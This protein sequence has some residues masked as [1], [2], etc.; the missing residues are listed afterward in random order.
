MAILAFPRFLSSSF[1]PNHTLSLPTT[2]F[3]GS[4]SSSAAAVKMS[5]MRGGG[6]AGEEYSSNPGG[7][8][9]L[10]F[11]HDLRIDDHPGLVAAASR[12]RTVIP[13]Y[14]FDHRILSRRL[15]PSLPLFFFFFFSFL[16]FD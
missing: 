6:A 1:S 13:L 5:M 4:S 2:R 8:A 9:V 10:W 15:L 7:A 16:H 3:L 12:Y 11:K 14:V